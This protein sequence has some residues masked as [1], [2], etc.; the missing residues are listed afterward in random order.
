M[1]KKVYESKSEIKTPVVNYVDN[2]CT[3]CSSCMQDAKDIEI[4]CADCYDD[5]TVKKNFDEFRAIMVVLNRKLEQIVKELD[6]K[7]AEIEKLKSDLEK[8]NPPKANPA[9][10]KNKAVK[11]PV[12]GSLKAVKK[13]VESSDEDSD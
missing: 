11:I 13:K 10:Q 3:K 4:L 12:K 9:A 1:D 6:S 7:N 5:F 8:S 2:S